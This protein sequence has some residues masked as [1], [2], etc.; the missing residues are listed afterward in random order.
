MVV[1][2]NASH[3]MVSEEHSRI[4]IEEHRKCFRLKTRTLRVNLVKSVKKPGHI[5]PQIQINIYV[6]E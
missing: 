5:T 1:Q 2:T 6:Y 4:L 3:N